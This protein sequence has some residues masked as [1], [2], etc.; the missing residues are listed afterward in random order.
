MATAFVTQL[1]AKFDP[2]RRHPF[3]GTPQADLAPGLRVVYHGAYAIF[4]MPHPDEIM[5]VRVIHCAR[6]I[7]GL[8]EKGAFG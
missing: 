1:E 8:A 7:A 3:L 5:I 4:Y 6:D 2:L